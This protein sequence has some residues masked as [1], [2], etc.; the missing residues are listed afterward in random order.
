MACM[1]YILSGMKKRHY[2]ISQPLLK[3]VLV[4]LLASCAPIHQAISATI[5]I[6]HQSHESI[7]DHAKEF[8]LSELR[9]VKPGDININDLDRRLKLT[10]CQQPLMVFWPPGARQ[11]GHTSIGVRC[12]GAKPW[13]V[14][15]QAKIRVMQSITVLKH[16][17]VRG[18]VLKRDMLQSVLKDTSR[19]GNQ[20]ISDGESL[21]GYRFKMPVG[22]GRVLRSNMLEMPKMIHRGETVKIIS[23]KGVIKVHMMGEALSDGGMGKIIRVRN[24]SS[25]RIIE[26][27]IVS[28]GTVRVGY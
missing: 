22:Q 12:Q 5:A 8:I 26:G 28:K 15:V 17:V 6:E 18:D 3:M 23:G 27:E 14:F 4:L 20:Y 9:D 25:R 7:R 10:R 13:K 11:S 2:L 19:L 21:L 1:L 24:K 16:A